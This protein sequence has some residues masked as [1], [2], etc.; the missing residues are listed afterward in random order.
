MVFPVVA[1]VLLFDKE[2]QVVQ[3]TIDDLALL[4]LMHDKGREFCGHILTG[5]MAE[6]FLEWSLVVNALSHEYFL[7]FFGAIIVQDRL[8]FF[9][10]LSRTIFTEVGKRGL[11]LALSVLGLIR[12]P[13]G[14]M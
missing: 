3:E 8:V 1:L 10:I 14:C 12:F 5:L 2:L 4:A 13:G 7:Q 11:P 6:T 9:H